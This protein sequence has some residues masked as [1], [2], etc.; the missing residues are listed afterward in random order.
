PELTRLNGTDGDGQE[1]LHETVTH[2]L[3][4][5]GNYHEFNYG[6]VK[7]SRGNLY[8]ALNTASSGGGIK[9]IVRGEVNLKGRDGDGRKQMYSV[10]PYRGWMMQFTP[11]GELI[12]YASGLRSPNGLG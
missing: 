12:P 8:F 3:G 4:I 1:D 9:E 6:P 11:Q 5:S 2:D 7:D 10:V